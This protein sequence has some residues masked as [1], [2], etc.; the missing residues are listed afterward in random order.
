M[1]QSSR[2]FWQ[3]S[4]CESLQEAPD[5]AKDEVQWNTLWLCVSKAGSAVSAT[6]A[7]HWYCHVKMS[8]DGWRV[9]HP[10]LDLQEEKSP[11]SFCVLWG[12][13]WLAL[14]SCETR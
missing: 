3:L 4:A 6:R 2:P 1:I 8:R 10:P 7:I 9:Y 14:F 13:I 11:F 12:S 5:S